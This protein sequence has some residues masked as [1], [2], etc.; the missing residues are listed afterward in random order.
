MIG[1]VMRTPTEM[2]ASTAVK[3]APNTRPSRSGGSDRCRAVTARPSTTRV[4]TPRT[5]WMPKAATGEVTT[6]RNSRVDRQ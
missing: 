1:G 6:T 2:A 5:P 3:K 4:P